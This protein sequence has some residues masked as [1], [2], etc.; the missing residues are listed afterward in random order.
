MRDLETPSKDNLSKILTAI[1][2]GFYVIPDFQREFEWGPWDIQALL[3]SIF[4]D[5]YIGTLLLWRSTPENFDKLN[6]EPIYGFLTKEEENDSKYKEK[7]RQSAQ[8]ILLDGQQRISALHYAFFPPKQPLPR[9]KTKFYYFVKIRSILEDDW[10][11]SIEYWN[12]NSSKGRTAEEFVG[13]LEQQFENGLFPLYLLGKGFEWYKWV[14]QY[15]KWLEKQGV[16]EAEKEEKVQKLEKFFQ[17]LLNSYDISYI[18]LSKDIDVAKVCDIFTKINSSGLK[19]TIFDLLNALL[20]PHDI[21]L[22]RD[23]RNASEIYNHKELE[24]MNIYLLQYMSIRLQAY[25]SPRYLYY[26]VPNTQRTIRKEDGTKEKRVIMNS[27]EEFKQYWEEAIQYTQK[28]LRKIENPRDFGSLQPKFIPYPTMI[29]ILGVLLKEKENLDSVLQQ[30]FD[31]KITQWYWA[32]VLS[33]SYS[34]SVESTMTKDYLDLKRWINDDTQ[35][36]VAVQKAAN[37]IENLD[38]LRENRQSSA[39][40]NAIFSLFAINEARDFYSNNLPEYSILEDHHI[41]PASWGKKNNVKDINSILN[42]APISDETNKKISDRLPNDYLLEIRKNIGNDQQFYDL[43]E[44]HL[45]SRKAV[46]IL[47]RDNF[48]ESDFNEFVQERKRTILSELKSIFGESEKDTILITPQSPYANTKHLKDIIKSQYGEIKWVDKYFSVVGL[49]LLSE[50]ASENNSTQLTSVKIL[51]SVNKVDHKI[52]EKF[53]TLREELQYK[54]ISAEMRVI[55][56]SDLKNQLHDR[57]LITESGTYNIP[58]TDTL[59]VGQYSEIRKTESELP[60]SDWWNQ[61]LDLILDWNR[62]E[63][64]LSEMAIQTQ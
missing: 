49:D 39:I 63:Q 13:P 54:G 43:M 44:S 23:W 19:L 55:T 37:T 15:G 17:S 33:N 51:T 28:A 38:L 47:L 24:K 35:A 57:W 7:L 34:S 1:D 11:E 20:K 26:L 21:E 6:C 3:Q 59:R 56:N 25:C 45:I 42:K 4:A 29:P 61:S 36:P 52:R 27:P 31:K 16:D 62:I 8:H 41:V 64:K 22:K 2:S 46:E 30:G 53:K 12:D 9:R 10:D 18:E 60:F 58:S 5:Y 14:V 50:I 32:S 40:Y 48:N